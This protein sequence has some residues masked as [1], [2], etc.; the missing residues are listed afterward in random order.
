MIIVEI[1]YGKSKKNIESIIYFHWD[2]RV[3][4]NNVISQI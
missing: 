1:N 4:V 3:L 2:G